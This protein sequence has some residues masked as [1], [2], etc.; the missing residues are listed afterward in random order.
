MQKIDREKL[1]V[2]GLEKPESVKKW[3]RT[4]LSLCHAEMLVHSLGHG[5]RIH[6]VVEDTHVKSRH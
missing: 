5:D 1:M 4:E 3:D 2:T 6:G